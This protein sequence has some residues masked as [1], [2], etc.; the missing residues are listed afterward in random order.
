[1]PIPAHAPLMAAMTGLGT[2]VVWYCGRPPAAASGPPVP[3]P[4]PCRVS[5]S[6]P[7]HQPLP[8]PVTTITFTSG[9][10]AHWSSNSK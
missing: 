8:A 3:P 1:M 2:S 4:S 7:A 6:A 5:M 9:S 10:A